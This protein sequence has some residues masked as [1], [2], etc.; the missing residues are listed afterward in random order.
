MVVGTAAAP[1]AA[2]ETAAGAG[3]VP[4]HVA[5]IMD[6]N[7]RWAR[8]RG[9]GRKAGHEAGSENIRRVIEHCARSGVSYLTL[10]AFSTEN[11]GRPK[12]EVGWLMRILGRVLKREINEL[13]ENGVRVRHL[14]RI[15]VLSRSLQRQVR[16]A[17]ALTAG[18]SRI[19]VCVAFNYGGRAE[20]VD[21]IRQIVADGIPASAIDEQT[22]AERLYTGGIPDPDLII[23][24]AGEM[25]I[26][27]FLLWQSAYSE[28]YVTDVFW[29]DVDAAVLDGAFAS[30]RGRER[31]F[32]RVPDAD[33]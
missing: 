1:A 2:T 3:S 7:G 19:T 11:W 31:R 5:I 23:R 25:R 29:P 33:A 14:G 21:A 8:A 10:Y 30:Y 16:D 24:T 20:I 18:N 28:L 22:V 15:E 13:H 27:N 4:A 9:K 6:G 26:S 32:G 17:E 12:Q